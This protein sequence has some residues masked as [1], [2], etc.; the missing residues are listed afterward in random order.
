MDLR[1]WVVTSAWPYINTVPHLGNMIGSILS[2]D[3]FA[4][5]LR[6]R[7]CDVVF[8]SGSDEHGTVIEVEARKKGV[9]PQE[10]TNDAHRYVS[11]LFNDWLISFDN[12]TRT[13]SEVHKEYVRSLMLRI[14][15]RGFIDVKEQLMPY[16][17]RDVIFLPDRFVYGTCP[18]CGYEDARGDQCD[19]C[20]RLLDPEELISPRC[21]FCGSRPIFKVTKHWFFRLDRVEKSLTEWLLNHKYLDDNVRNYSLSWI[22]HGLKPRSVTRDN[23]WGISASFPG[24]ED[25]TIYVWFE[26]LLG[27]VSATVEYFMKLGKANEW[28]EFWFNPEAGTA[29]FIGKDNIPFHAIILPAMFMASGEG[30]NLPTIISAT[31]YL[32][33]E[34]QKFSKSRRIGIWIDEA[35]EI[36]PEPDYWRFALIRMR[37]EGRDT[38]FTWSDFV[39]IIN[40]ELNDDIGNYV[41]RILTLIHR[42]FNGFI[43]K[44]SRLSEV[45]IE[46]MDKIKYSLRRYCELM[47]V[48]KI[49]AAT[50]VILEL[51]RSGNQYLNI[52]QPWAKL[53][54]DPDDAVTTLYYGF[55]SILAL[56][57]MLYPIIPKSMERLFKIINVNPRNI[58]IYEDVNLEEIHAGVIN[59]PEP[60]FKKLDRSFLSNI[61]AIISEARLK[62]HQKRPHVLK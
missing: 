47:N 8:V 31:E 5:Y 23:K 3:V 14:Y 43:P 42:E 58:K 29:Y 15:E 9:E 30:Y 12:Y 55:L 53:K 21:V 34:G 52:K 16:C 51:A 59:K 28:R 37:P 18:Y 48:A 32:M 6:L 62:A 7:G 2:A 36:I 56:T 61:D 39:R 24:A 44:P 17:N 13:E 4:R 1:K 57:L 49:R 22:K 38:N 46:F 26:A 19:S 40:D 20:G 11:K 54:V 45:D 41:H 35:L 27:Y 50:E 60:L 10:L 25:K 33:F